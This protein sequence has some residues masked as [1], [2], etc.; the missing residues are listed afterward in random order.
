MKRAERVRLASQK[1]NL[2]PAAVEA[3]LDAIAAALKNQKQQVDTFGNKAERKQIRMLRDALRK[4]R[5]YARSDTLPRM[6]RNAITMSR[7][8][9]WK[10]WRGSTKP[11]TSLLA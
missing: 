6:L 9:L 4:T 5:D 1:F 11:A 8:G 10:S 2:A 3:A 7:A